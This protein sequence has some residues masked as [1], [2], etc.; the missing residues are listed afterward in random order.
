MSR[1]HGVPQR[2]KKRILYRNQI[3][4]EKNYAEL[5]RYLCK[6]GRGKTSATLREASGLSYRRVEQKKKRPRKKKGE[7]SFMLLPYREKVGRGEKKKTEARSEAESLSLSSRQTQKEGSNC[8]L[9]KKGGRANRL[10]P[11]PFGTSTRKRE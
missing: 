6:K 10:Y 11:R 5:E 7:T 4:W 8:V 1:C 2:K 9:R 3:K